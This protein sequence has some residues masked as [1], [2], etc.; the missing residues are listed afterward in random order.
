MTEVID[1]VIVF[2]PK[3]ARKISKSTFHT[4]VCHGVVDEEEGKKVE[5][6]D[7]P[8]IQSITVEE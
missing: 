5:D 8:R 6:E 4:T 2:C 1:K 3:K 7:C